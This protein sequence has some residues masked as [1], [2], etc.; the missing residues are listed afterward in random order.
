MKFINM[1]NYIKNE[2]SNDGHVEVYQSEYN[3]NQIPEFE[4]VSNKLE[5]FINLKLEKF[6]N[7]NKLKLTNFGLL[8]QKIRHY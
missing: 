8:S 2:F 1:I 5:K 3:L 6:I 7:Y 4:K